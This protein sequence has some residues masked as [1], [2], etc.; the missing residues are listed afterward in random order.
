MS[1]PILRVTPLGSRW[2]TQDPFLF[3]VHHIDHYP[4]GNDR[5]GPDASLAG[6]DL[7]QDFAGQDGWRMYHGTVIPGFPQ[8]PHR[9]FE[10]VTIVRRGYIDHSDSL[11]ATA[12]FGMGDVQWLTAGAGVVH[13]EM[14]PLLDADAPNPLELFQIWLNLPAR[15]KLAPPYFT[16]FW[17]PD[18]P[19]LR[20]MDAGGR[21]IEVTVIAGALDGVTPLAPPPHSWAASDEADVA[22]WS[23][24]LDEGATWTVPAARGAR[25]LRTLHVFSGA[26]LRVGDTEVPAPAA[27][28]V[29]PDQ[30]LTIEATRGPVEIL[31]LQGRPI[32]EPVAQHGPF[33]MNTRAELEQAFADY[34][35]TSFGGWPFREPAPVH[36]R[37]Q[38]RFAKHADGR[39]E[40][41]DLTGVR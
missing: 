41:P 4:K 38:G 12:R 5:L 24:A 25:T 28:H 36:P 15:N 3:C 39:V 26:A 8:H 19:R 9:G 30:P 27:I 20:E 2:Q 6:R 14:F 1:D 13:S 31:L 17:D 33:V 7:G 10:T 16:M 35:S 11:G 22:I 21:K 23:I 40:A 34:R 29:R 18:I 37:G 32:G